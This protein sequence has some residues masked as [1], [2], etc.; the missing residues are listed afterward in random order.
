MLKVLQNVKLENDRGLLRIFLK[1][2]FQIENIISKGQKST[3]SQVLIR[4]LKYSEFPAGYLIK[5][6]KFV[7]N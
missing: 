6:V 7:E 1:L 2:I 5:A 3:F 4:S